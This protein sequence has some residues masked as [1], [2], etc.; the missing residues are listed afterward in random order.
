MGESLRVMHLRFFKKQKNRLKDLV[1]ICICWLMLP[2]CGDISSRKSVTYPD[3][4]IKSIV[5][6][7]N[8][9]PEWK[10][11]ITEA[12]KSLLLEYDRKMCGVDP[13][14]LKN[15]VSIFCKTQ[16]GSELDY[17]TQSKNKG[18]I[19][20]LIRVLFDVPAITRWDTVEYFG[21]KFGTPI[22]RDGNINLL[23]PLYKDEN[24]ALGF[25]SE[26]HH[27]VSVLFGPPYD[28]LREFESIER[29]FPRRKCPIL[30]RTNP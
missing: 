30:I 16:C 1:I 2:G 27:A 3:S 15:A 6:S 18:K 14:A 29:V 13:V 26:K 24:G 20:L 28:P 19:F 7:I 23:W 25:V 4:D 11:N 17:A 9:I 10:L 21:G 22:D 5:R 12:D 8:D